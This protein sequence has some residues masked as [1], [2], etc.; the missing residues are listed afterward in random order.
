MLRLFD[1]THKPLL[2]DVLVDLGQVD[3]THLR[4]ALNEQRIGEERIG[5][6]LLRL[7]LVQRRSLRRALFEQRRRWL[8]T[9]FAAAI[10]ALRPLAVVAR[11]AIAQLSVSVQVAATLTVAAVPTLI[12]TKSTPTAEVSLSCPS[13]GLMRV[14]ISIARFEL[15]PD[16]TGSNPFG[17]QALSYHPALKPISAR[18]VACAS[19]SGP[20]SVALPWP[21]RTIAAGDSV[22]VE[23]AY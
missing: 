6:T 10:M 19:G 3:R 15:V 18:S 7:G 23:T 14:T 17:T 5:E 13:A 11:T 9:S 22:V 21:S 1:S 4:Y 20:M 2:G 16:A 8:R 12:A